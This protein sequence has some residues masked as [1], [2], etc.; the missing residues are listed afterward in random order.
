MNS[1]SA[2]ANEIREAR[3]KACTQISIE[4]KDWIKEKYIHT[5]QDFISRC[6]AYMSMVYAFESNY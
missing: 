6:F 3:I 5:N 1:V 4:Y 2:S